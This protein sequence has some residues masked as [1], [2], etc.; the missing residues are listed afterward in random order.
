MKYKAIASGY[1]GGGIIVCGAV[2]VNT[3]EGIITPDELYTAVK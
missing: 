1:V 3:L 2:K